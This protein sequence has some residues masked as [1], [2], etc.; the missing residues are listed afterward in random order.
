MLT[1]QPTVKDGRNEKALDL[2]MLRLVNLA[3]VVVLVLGNRT[4]RLIFN[5]V[6]IS[7]ANLDTKKEGRTEE[8]REAKCDW[9]REETER[10]GERE[11]EI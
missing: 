4:A 10:E 11:R 7:F 9:V 8:R 6:P 1:S 3:T 2:H 5:Q